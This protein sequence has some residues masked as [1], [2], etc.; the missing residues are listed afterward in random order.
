[1]IWDEFGKIL[2]DASHKEKQDEFDRFEVG[3][4]ICAAGRRWRVT[5]VIRRGPPGH[6]KYAI[7]RVSDGKL[8]VAGLLPEAWTLV[9][10]P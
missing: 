4:I 7:R 8:G 3:N 10:H 1:M 9:K 2:D 6:A 5:G